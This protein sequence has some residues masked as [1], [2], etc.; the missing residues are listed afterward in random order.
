MDHVCPYDGGYHWHARELKLRIM[1]RSTDWL[2][3][4][5]QKRRGI[6][7]GNYL[8]RDI[9]GR[10]QAVAIALSE[11]RRSGARIPKKKSS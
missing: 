9:T 5:W 4:C 6:L 11:A 1:F 10:K 8:G 7:Y 2:P 3:M